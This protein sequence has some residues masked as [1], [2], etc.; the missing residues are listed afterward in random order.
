MPKQNTWRGAFAAV[1]AGATFGA[2]AQDAAPASAGDLEQRILILER[3]LEIQDEDARAKAKDAAVTT[4]GEKGFAWKSGDGNFEFKFRGLLQADGRFF[5]G[6][7]AGSSYVDT[8]LLRR[9]EPTFELTLGKLAYFRLQPQFAGDSASTADVYGELRFHPAFTV[10]AGKFK[11]PLVLENLQSTGSITFIER[12]LPNELGANR[13]LGVQVQGELLS[14]TTTYALG[15][16]NGAPDGRDSAATDTDNR[17]EL[18]GRLFF[19]PFRNEPGFFQ[20]L[21]FGVGASQGEKITAPSTTAATSSANFNNSLPRYRSPGQK[22]VFTY[23]IDSTAPTAANT[24]VANGTFTRVSPQLYFYRDS[25]GLIGEYIT[26]KQEVAV[27]GATTAFEH[28]AYQGQLSYV[29]TG[30]DASYRG[31]KPANPY[32]PAG[33]GWGAVELAARY[34]VL[35]IDDAVF[36]GGSSTTGFADPAKSITEERTVG[37]ALNWY[38][39]GNARLGLNYDETRFVGGATGGDRDT[40]Q[41]LFTRFQLSF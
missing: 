19:E 22:D 27:S 6:D 36:V 26:S 25:F 32:I 31:V 28:V 16:F 4:I 7:P 24:V 40:E 35:D 41:A 9:V 23:R 30:E 39:T 10:R 11:E 2:T 15:V 21:G 1:L 17:K 18:A 37:V 5:T 13:D 3:K 8:V 20:G 29:L 34:G 33:E 38:L 14:G 12:G